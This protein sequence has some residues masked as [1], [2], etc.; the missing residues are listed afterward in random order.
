MQIHEHVADFP[1]RRKRNGRHVHESAALSAQGDF[2]ANKQRPAFFDVVRRQQMSDALRRRCGEFAL[3]NSLVASR[4]NNVDGC[5][6]AKQH[7][8]RTDKNRLARAPVSPV[9][10]GQA[11]IERGI[12]GLDEREI[13]D[14]KRCEHSNDCR[15]GASAHR[16]CG[17]TRFLPPLAKNGGWVSRS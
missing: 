1:E 4:A 11:G 3:D 7:A 9:I 14:G 17:V 8:Q 15:T 6:L 13:F 5:A 12:D 2:A 10:D 16:P